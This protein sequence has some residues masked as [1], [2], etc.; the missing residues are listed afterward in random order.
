MVTELGIHTADLDAGKLQVESSSYGT[1]FW[2]KITNGDGA[3]NYTEI[4]IFAR[5]AE[6]QTRIENSLK[7]ALRLSDVPPGPPVDKSDLARAY[8]TVCKTHHEHEGDLEF[9]DNAKV[10]GADD[11]P[12]AY[13][14]CWKWVARTELPERF[15]IEETE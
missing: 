3:G 8:R 5:D 4:A 9:D 12:G 2:T 11:A 6:E 7:Y 13:V 15:Q 14:Q 1:T 10:S